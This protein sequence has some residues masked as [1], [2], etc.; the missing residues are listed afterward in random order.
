MVNEKVKGEYIHV[1]YL[2]LI[3]Y[4]QLTLI[5]IVSGHLDRASSTAVLLKEVAIWKGSVLGTAYLSST[6]DDLSK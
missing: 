3:C 5:L 4:T 6:G 2:R 1:F